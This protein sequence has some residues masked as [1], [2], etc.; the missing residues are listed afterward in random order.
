MK[1]NKLFFLALSAAVITACSSDKIN[2]QP[3]D[4]D[5]VVLQSSYSAEKSAV[6]INTQWYSFNLPKGCS[7]R[8][9]PDSDMDYKVYEYKITPAISGKKYGSNMYVS[10]YSEDNEDI[11][12]YKEFVNVNSQNILRKGKTVVWEKYE[13]VREVMLSGRKAFVIERNLRHFLFPNSKDDRYVMKKEK[14]YVLPASK[15]Y[16]VIRYFAEESEFPNNINAFEEMSASF[17][18]KY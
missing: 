16:Y 9:D 7:A 15:G 8:N 11:A 1:Q 3:T 14:M 5:P 6:P 4:V 17:K 2:T 12:T 13:P 18:G 10:Y